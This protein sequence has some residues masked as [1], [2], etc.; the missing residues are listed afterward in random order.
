MS[1]VALVTGGS[2]GIGRGV[3]EALAA[4]GYRVAANYHSNDEAAASLA[5]ATGAKTYKWDVADY[6]ACKAGVAQVVANLGPVEVLV[7]NAGISPDKFMHKMAPDVW[8]KVIDTNL[9]SAFNVTHQVIGEMRNA[10]FGR[11]VNIASLSAFAPNYGET[12]YGAAKGAMVS[13]TK[14]L[15]KESAA[16]G[17]T[18]NA[19]A[20]GYIDTDMIRVAPQ[21]FL[22]DLVQNHILVGRLGR[23]EDVAR[24][25]LFLAADDADFITGATID[26]N[27][28]Q[29]MR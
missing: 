1:R 12:A 6:D 18:V 29:V 28:G 26:V 14:A 5:E 2:R 25:V 27:G 17:V 23:V 15:A 9:N 4:A 10:G 24:C 21:E 13:F 19:I 3:A 20:P 11:V 16:K 7:N 8:R 22:D